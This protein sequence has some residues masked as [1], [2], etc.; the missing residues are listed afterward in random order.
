MK[1]C[2]AL[3][4]EPTMNHRH[5]EIVNQLQETWGI[6]PV[7][8]QLP[9][10]VTVKQV[11]DGDLTE[12]LPIVKGLAKNYS[13]LAITYDATD[14]IHAGEVD[15]IWLNVVETMVL[16]EIHN[17]LN[18]GLKVPL[19]RFDGQAFHFH[20]TLA[21]Q[22]GPLHEAHN[23]LYIDLPMS[24]ELQQLAVFVSK[25]GEPGTFTLYKQWPLGR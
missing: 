24:T 9:A 14:L 13:P 22:Q 7:A 20:T 4:T 25:T 12:V 2:I 18:Q 10:H 17:A 11:F 6:K 21:L 8:G 23:A 5:K 1:I 19:N 16:R 15:I 3:V